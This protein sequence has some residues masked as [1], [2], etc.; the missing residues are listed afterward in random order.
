MEEQ[1]FSNR[2]AP[3]INEANVIG[4]MNELNEAVSYPRLAA[5]EPTS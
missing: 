1:N 2:F 5:Y 4:I 3:F